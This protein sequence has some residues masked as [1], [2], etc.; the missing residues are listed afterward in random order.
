[1]QLTLATPERKLYENTEILKLVV[2]TMQGEITVLPQHVPLMSSLSRGEMQVQLADKQTEAVF[3]SGGVIQ[4]VDNFINIL[5][6][7]AEKAH[8][9]DEAATEEAIRRAQLQAQEKVENVDMADI[10]AKLA[11][12]I[13]R[14]KLISKYKGKKTH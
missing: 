2:P 7:V 4:V 14:L 1:M 5:A 13:A 3:V 9:I 11:N 12:D 8:E 10:Q 6:N